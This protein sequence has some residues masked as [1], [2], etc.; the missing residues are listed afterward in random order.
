MK[1]SWSPRWPILRSRD[2]TTTCLRLGTR[3]RVNIIHLKVL[4]RTRGITPLVRVVLRDLLQV[5]VL[6]KV[7]IFSPP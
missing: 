4:A 5:R 6:P 1:L 2:T 3:R 7:S